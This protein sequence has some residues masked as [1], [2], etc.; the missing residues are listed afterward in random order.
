M[1][2]FDIVEAFEEKVA[3]YAGAPFGV[4]VNSCTSAIMLSAKLRFEQGYER[5]AHL[6]A[7]TYVGVPQAILAAG[8]R[9]EFTAY[10]WSGGYWIHHL[11]IFDGARRFRMG[12][13]AGGLHCL[14][15]HWGKHLPV[16]RGGMILTDS[17]DERN[18]LR[19]MRY[20]GRTPGVPPKDDK[21]GFGW[22]VYMIPEDAARGLMLMTWAKDEY[23]DLPWDDYADLSKCPQFT[24]PIF[25]RDA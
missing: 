3:A 15:F 5:V 18:A 10:D 21:F 20:D 17:V 19:R 14:S 13:Y 9:C 1:Q 4:A 22:H 25:R 2:P 6:P 11:R 24:I 7:L 12:M 16:G 23:P 8:G